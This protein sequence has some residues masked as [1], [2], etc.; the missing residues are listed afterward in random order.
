M[1]FL[2]WTGHGA[3]L[4]ADVELSNFVA[5][6]FAGVGDIYGN[7]GLSLRTDGLSRET[8]IAVLESGVAQAIAE[9]KQRLRARAQVFTFC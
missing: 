8:Q 1:Q 9:G 5:T 6:Q 4:V 2:D 7:F 3:D